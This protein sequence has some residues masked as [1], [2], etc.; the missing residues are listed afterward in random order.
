MPGDPIHEER[1]FSPQELLCFDGES[2]RI[3]IAYQGIVYDLTDCPKWR[4]GM[5]E[6]LHFPGQDLTTEIIDAPHQEEVFL[7]PC[8]KRVGRLANH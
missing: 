4:T 8:V 2:S 5:H 7:R 6:G 1:I 3:Y